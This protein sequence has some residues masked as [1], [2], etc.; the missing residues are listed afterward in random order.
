MWTVRTSNGGKNL[1]MMG[2]VPYI[3]VWL[4]HSW[5]LK[6]LKTRSGEGLFFNTK[7]TPTADH[8]G[9]SR[10]S[11]HSLS[12]VLQIPLNLNVDCRFNTTVHTTKVKD[13]ILFPPMNKIHI[14][15]FTVNPSVFFSVHLFTFHSSVFQQSLPR[16]RWHKRR[17]RQPCRSSSGCFPARLP[18][19]HWCRQPGCSLGQC[20]KHKTI[21]VAEK[22]MCRP[23]WMAKINRLTVVWLVPFVYVSLYLFLNVHCLS[24]RQDLYT[25]SS[26]ISRIIKEVAVTSPVANQGEHVPLSRVSR[27]ETDGTDSVREL[28]RFC[29]TDQGDQVLCTEM[30]AYAWKLIFILVDITVITSK[31][32]FIKPTSS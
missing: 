16:P 9:S 29:Q 10:I 15:L 25:Y 18:A 30:C 12:D 32:S 5:Q 1:G 27:R 19:T 26:Q 21:A 8:F 7:L 11:F 20:P 28:Q 31:R 14:V 2:C 3:V 6:K 24:W 4:K 17:H 22:N 13:A 23:Q